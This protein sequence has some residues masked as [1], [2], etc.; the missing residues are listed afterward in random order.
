[1]EKPK[2]ATVII[3][4]LCAVLWIFRVIVG[5]VSKEF[6]DSVWFFVLNILGAIIWVSAFIKWLI[7]YRSDDN[8]MK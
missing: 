5:I 6:D 3:Y 4:G 8:E 2:L 7:R 1:M